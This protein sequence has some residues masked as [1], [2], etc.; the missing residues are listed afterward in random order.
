M[1]ARARSLAVRTRGN[2]K[3]R[4]IMPQYNYS[5]IM[6]LSIETALGNLKNVGGKVLLEDIELQMNSR[7]VNRMCS[8]YHLK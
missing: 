1:L 5:E 3:V 2:G 4:F 7:L 8:G 6:L